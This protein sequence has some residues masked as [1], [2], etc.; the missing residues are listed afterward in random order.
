MVMQ[1]KTVALAR[2]FI[3]HE[4]ARKESNEG[5]RR[6]RVIVYRKG[7]CLSKGHSVTLGNWTSHWSADLS[8]H[9][10]QQLFRR[11]KTDDERGGAETN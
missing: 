3:S 9:T 11:G 8:F 2:A 7:T 5:E 6:E 4:C 1:E 10:G